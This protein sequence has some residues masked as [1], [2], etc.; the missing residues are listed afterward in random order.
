MLASRTNNSPCNQLVLKDTVGFLEDSA[1][2]NKN[3]DD[4][5]IIHLLTRYSENMHFITITSIIYKNFN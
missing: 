2:A 3:K 1:K 4:S 5:R